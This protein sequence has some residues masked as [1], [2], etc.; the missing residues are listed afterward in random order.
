[1]F[2]RLHDL[3]AYAPL[4]KIKEFLHDNTT[5]DVNMK[6]DARNWTPLHWA[7]FG[8]SPDVVALI[9]SLPGILVNETC[10]HGWT[11][12]WLA[13]FHSNCDVARVLLADPRVDVDMADDYDMTPLWRASSFGSLKLIKSF[14]ASGRDFA[15]ERK[16][17]VDRASQRVTPLEIAAFNCHPEVVSMLNRFFADRVGTRR[18]ISLELGMPDPLAADLFATV[19]FLCDGFLN[20]RPSF[21]SSPSGRFFSIVSRLPMELQM[22]MCWRLCG[23]A[24]QNIQS[25][26]AEAAFRMLVRSS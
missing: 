3:L 4:G 11:P 16:G 23:S 21:V 19:V 15:W 9:L 20:L 6:F 24:K 22:M 12:F 13:C 25:R 26:D 7:S 17:K 8:G 10:E 18:E 14:I 5:F 2:R 1:M